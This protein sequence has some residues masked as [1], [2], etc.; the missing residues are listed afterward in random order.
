M[1]NEEVR[2]GTP[3]VEG[4]ALARGAQGAQAAL[5]ADGP[6]VVL[7]GPPGAGKTT[8]G[9]RL[10][11]A[12]QTQL[13]DTDALIAERMGMSCA[14]VL[15]SQGEPA[16]R[17]IEA[18]MIADALQRGGV[19]SLGGGAVVTAST[20]QLLTEYFVVWLD[21]SVAEGV[22]R[23]SRE[24]TRPLLSGG[25]IVQRYTD[26]LTQRLELYHEVADY[27]VRTD[28]RTPQQIV[29]DILG[30]L[31]VE[32]SEVPHLVQAGSSTPRQQEQREGE[33]ACD[34]AND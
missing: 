16:F 8:V 32:R 15:T 29:A 14:D 13:H 34:A 3:T 23:T 24:S 6:A 10:A 7:V 20:R 1:A 5:G 18:E 9:R 33:D 2:G 19:V 30:H 17:A 26:L 22:R 12:L 31:E 11:N 4:E 28:G 27:R 21:V 25:N